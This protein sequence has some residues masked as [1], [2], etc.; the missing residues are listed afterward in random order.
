MTK[1]TAD[2]DTYSSENK[3]ILD[4][5]AL[6]RKGVPDEY[7]KL[8]DLDLCGDRESILFFEAAPSRL[9]QLAIDI[10][11]F[12]LKNFPYLTD[13]TTD[14]PESWYSEL[15]GDKAYPTFVQSTS[16]ALECFKMN[17]EAFC[18][19][20]ANG[21]Y[22]CDLT[23]MSKYD[24]RSGFINY[25]GDIVLDSS[26][27][28]VISVSGLSPT[29]TD[30][31]RELNR[32]LASFA[33]HI[34]VDRHAT[35][36]HLAVSQR[37]AMEITQPQYKEVYDSN[38]AIKK[39]VQILTTRVNEVSLNEQLL[40]GPEYSLVSRAAS[41]TN[42]SLEQYCKDK[43]VK[44]ISLQ[45]DELVD[46]LLPC[47]GSFKDAGNTA[48]AAA[49]T[50]ANGVCKE[51]LTQDV[52]EKL[53]LMLWNASF[54]HYFVGDY[55]IRNLVFGQLPLA[56]TGKDHVQNQKY[57]TLSTTIAATTMTRALNVEDVVEL[58]QDDEGKA[59]WLE[60]WEATKCL[61]GTLP[62]SSLEISYP[63]VNF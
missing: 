1:N 7:K 63:A 51:F 46:M 13:G 37:I 16:S 6:L 14:F 19:R 44:Y 30:F 42:E 12:G 55:Q 25:G 33:V 8:D 50:L 21:N 26:R 62:G 18:S 57:A 29:S 35:M 2:S 45:P 22:T 38:S 39:L 52:V 60:F 28:Q 41:F 47:D 15:I 43:Y 23:D 54:Y 36:V 48:Y 49:K 20:D 61:E 27:E 4:L 9:H 58:L 11:S 56:C 10:S 59:N 5:L 17:A 24:V 31:D 40:I 32:F 34:I 3:I 53:A